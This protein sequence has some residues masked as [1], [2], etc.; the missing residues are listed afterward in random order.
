MYILKALRSIRN[1]TVKKLFRVIIIIYYAA[2]NIFG[3]A[4]FFMGR[5]FR[6]IHSREKFSKGSIK[7]I[8]VIRLDKVGDVI[9]SLPVITALRE[10]FP[11]SFIGFLSS[12]YTNDLIESN[13]SINEAILYEERA[14][15]FRRIGFMY[16]LK[17]YRFDLAIVLSPYFESSLVA[18]LSGA[19]FRVGYPANG[20][21]F[22]LTDKISLKNRFKH[23]IESSLDVVRNIGI[24]TQNK[25]PIL[26]IP[27]IDRKFAENFFL[28][29]QIS[30]SDLVIGIH[31]SASAQYKC[32]PA[33]YFAAVSDN[34]IEKHQA[35]IIL[36]GSKSDIAIIDKI[37][38]LARHAPVV[39]DCS[40]N[41]MQV[42]GLISN[43]S[44][45]LGNNSGPMH[46]AAAVGTPT[47]AIFGNI[48]PLDSEKKWAPP[49]ENNIVV[50]KNMDCI[51][52]HPG[53]CRD[54]RCINEV[55]MA[56]VLE[57]LDKQIKRLK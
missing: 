20:S 40:F 9:C 50:R 51:G 6:L 49:G 24:D 31:P 34:L 47:V 54:Y 39:A 55:A 32:W 33:D 38:K 2:I 26:E 4:I 45:F 22:L 27:D 52:C 17:K 15:L 48:H 16:S 13:S 28:E 41:L 37:L 5:W 19:K 56:D 42:A 46:I 29:R 30:P 23:E 10:N 36:F 21:A 53:N 44:I 1:K 11:H 25:V 18:F 14:S 12:A 3:S 7:R 8:L 43:C 35:K 57:A